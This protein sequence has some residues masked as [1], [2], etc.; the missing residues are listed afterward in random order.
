MNESGET[1]LHAKIIHLY[2]NDRLLNTNP[3][4]SKMYEG[5]HNILPMQKSN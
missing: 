3:V 2:R 5:T 4:F 1:E